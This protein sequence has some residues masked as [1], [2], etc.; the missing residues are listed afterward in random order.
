VT[1]IELNH[2]E[3]S[4]PGPVDVGLPPGAVPETPGRSP[5]AWPRG[6]IAVAVVAAALLWSY[7]DQLRRLWENWREDPNYSHGYLVIPVAAAI[8]WRR[9]GRPGG[10]A[11]RPW[12]WGWLVLGASLAARGYFHEYGHHS[13]EAATLLPVLGGLVLALGGWGLWRRAWPAIAY[14][15][16]MVPLPGAVNA[17]LAQPLQSLATDL[18]AKLL[19]LSGAWVITEG[20]VIFVGAQKLPLN[21]AEA[22]S[23]LSMLLCLLATVTAT[24]LLVPMSVWTRAVLMISAV[25]IALVSN[26][27]RVAA[28][29]WCV[30]RF[31]ESGHRIGHDLSGWLMMPLAMLLVGLE[32]AVLTRLVT[33]DEIETEPMLLGRPIPARPERVLRRPGVTPPPSPPTPL[34]PGERGDDPA[35]SPGGSGPG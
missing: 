19:Q 17:L 8:F 3:L 28:T 1:E 35:L 26:V 29:A 14:L 20:N 4:D 30:Q 12:Q 21:V 16:F 34:P 27:L 2:P 11:T 25:P 6:A 15:I 22:C 9:G 31:G 23:G 10:T 7:A 13:A 24:V 32:L 33:E 18:S 5:G